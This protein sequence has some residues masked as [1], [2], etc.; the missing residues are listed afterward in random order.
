MVDFLNKRNVD[1]LFG[2]VM[3]EL[4]AP[5]ES[6]EK[7]M[8]ETI[9]VGNKIFHRTAQ[10]GHDD[11]YLEIYKRKSDKEILFRYTPKGSNDPL[12]ITCTQGRMVLPWVSLCIFPVNGED[13]DCLEFYKY[14]IIESEGYAKSYIIPF[15]GKVFKVPAVY[16]NSLCLHFTKASQSQLA[17]TVYI[18][19]T[20]LNLYAIK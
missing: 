14:L 8:A 5:V 13:Q 19:V 11:V 3:K 2:K 9:Q 10:I 17:K 1:L 6:K 4:P 16:L 15:R 12:V 20:K 7:V 18:P